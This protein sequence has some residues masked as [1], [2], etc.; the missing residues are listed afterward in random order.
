MAFLKVLNLPSLSTHH[1][2]IIFIDSIEPSMAV[3]WWES[4]APALT[5]PG[6]PSARFAALAWREPHVT[7]MHR[8]TYRCHFRWWKHRSLEPPKFP[9]SSDDPS[10]CHVENN[11]AKNT[12]KKKVITAT[13]FSDGFLTLNYTTIMSQ[14]AI[15]LD[16]LLAGQLSES[17]AFNSSNV[18]QWKK[19]QGSAIIVVERRPTLF[20]ETTGG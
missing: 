15:I 8:R 11:V 4:S 18:F 2:H 7:R 13:L 5:A 19:W 17:W 9:R 14:L 6:A 20:V 12:H 3:L 10:G 16:L 1:P